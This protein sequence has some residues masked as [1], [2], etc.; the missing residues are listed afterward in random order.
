M[1]ETAAAKPL[2]RTPFLRGLRLSRHRGLLIAI[3]VFAFFGAMPTRSQPRTFAIAPTRANSRSQ[4]TR[5]IL[6]S[7]ACVEWSC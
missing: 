2:P 7:T 3:A 6:C 5:M 4:P 1:S